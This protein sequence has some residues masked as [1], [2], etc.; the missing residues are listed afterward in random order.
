M[1]AL[2]LSHVICKSSP[3]AGDVACI[4]FPHG[5]ATASMAAFQWV[6][7]WTALTD[8][9]GFNELHRECDCA[10]QV[11]KNCNFKCWSSI[12]ML[13]ALTFMTNVNQRSFVTI[14][15]QHLLRECDGF[16]Y[17]Y[18]YTF[19]R[20][21][22]AFVTEKKFFCGYLT[23]CGPAVLLPTLLGVHHNSH[24]RLHSSQYK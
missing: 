3:P 21:D 12:N 20:N 17:K 16:Y 19:N 1:R 22:P 9:N 18:L 6:L 24:T 4:P 7:P 11:N 10:R 5:S 2:F 15:I 23:V 13:P 8:D 14:I